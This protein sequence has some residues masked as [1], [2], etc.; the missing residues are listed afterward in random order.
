MSLPYQEKPPF[1]QAIETI[2]PICV[3]GMLASLTYFMIDL[4][5]AVMPQGVEMMRWVLFFFIL[6]AVGINRIRRDQEEHGCSWVV[7]SVALAAVTLLVLTARTGTVG[8][9]TGQ[10]MSRSLA[11]LINVAIVAVLWFGADRITADCSLDGVSEESVA[12]GLLTADKGKRRKRVKRPGLLIVMLALPAA[13]FFGLSRLVLPHATAAVRS[14]AWVSAGAYIFFSLVL[15]ALTSAR[16][17][18]MYL[19]G[20]KVSVPW[21]AMAIWVATGMVIAALSLAVASVFPKPNLAAV[22]MT[23]APGGVAA[24]GKSLPLQPG[25]GTREPRPGKGEDMADDGDRGEMPGEEAGGREAGQHPGEEGEEGEGGA[26]GGTD[27]D[28]GRG[29][30]GK[31]KGAAAERGAAGRAGRGS[32]IQQVGAAV[33]RAAEFG[34]KLLA[35]LIVL[36]LLA[37]AL[38]FL[39]PRLLRAL[40]N[41]RGWRSWWQRFLA[42]FKRKPKAPRP[43][44]ARLRRFAN[45]FRAAGLLKKMSPSELARYTYEALL[46]Y[47]GQH[48]YPR[49]PEETPYE[50]AQRLSDSG[51]AMAT[52]AAS[53]ART[54]VPAEY[55]SSELPASAVDE[56][57]DVWNGLEAYAP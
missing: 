15:L 41:V 40:R 34:K 7:L 17:Q 2:T 46:T 3:F 43:G 33:A 28:G 35:I 53:A 12:E 20:R 13:V 18:R 23:R 38:L 16:L 14:H 39:F 54:Y 4:R 11:L 32:M 52:L 55:G 27:E 5:S 8:A 25:A 44:P 36:A 57:R 47:A 31:E 9:F 1:D 30:N 24:D 49:Q 6:A 29:K 21:K 45:P 50:F 56:L 10:R 48:G 22:L 26:G 19:V 51:A 37:A 42:S